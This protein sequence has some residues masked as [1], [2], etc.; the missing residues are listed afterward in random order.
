MDNILRIPVYKTDDIVIGD[1]IA[2]WRDVSGW[3][4][5]ARVTKITP[6]Y[7]EVIQNSRIKTSGMNRTRSVHDETNDEAH[8]VETTTNADTIDDHDH[9]PIQSST[10]PTEAAYN[11]VDEAMT[12]AADHPYSE[13]SASPVQGI[14]SQGICGTEMQRV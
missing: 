11:E 6:Y 2:I 7:Y 8:Y 13:K 4:A 12:E 14:S 3:L 10:E 1:T 5:P 9:D